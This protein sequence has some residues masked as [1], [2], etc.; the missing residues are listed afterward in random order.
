MLSKGILEADNRTNIQF[1]NKAVIDMITD[2]LMKWNYGLVK[3]SFPS[4]EP[5]KAEFVPPVRSI[6]FDPT[7]NEV[8]A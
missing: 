3:N 8:H 7:M 2:L 4:T 5:K 1:A 6:Y